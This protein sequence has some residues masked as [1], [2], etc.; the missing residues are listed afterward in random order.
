MAK[1]FFDD[2]MHQANYWNKYGATKKNEVLSN[3]L[4]LLEK[5]L[6]ER[7]SVRHCIYALL[8]RFKNIIYCKH[9]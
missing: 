6:R 1:T 7:K 8:F 9:L 2:R 5:I 4:V 3:K